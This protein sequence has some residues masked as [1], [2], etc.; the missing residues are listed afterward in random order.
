VSAGPEITIATD[1]D[2]KMAF[3]CEDVSTDPFGRMSFHILVEQ[4]NSI[5]FPAQTPILFV[6]FSF[7]RKL[8][9]FLM[10]CAVDIVPPSGDPVASQKVQDV[11]FRP[12]QLGQRV[13]VA[14]TGLSWP[15]AADYTVRFM[16]R[17]QCV[18]SFALRLTQIAPPAAPGP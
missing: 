17:E 10:N 8:P 13:V 2:V 14:F 7:V 9:G 11:A 15:R 1:V 16:T 3:A 5:V 12:D 18:S 4:I 6:V